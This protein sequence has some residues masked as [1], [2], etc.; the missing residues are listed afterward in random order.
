MPE[1]QRKCGYRKIGGL[2]LVCDGGKDFVCDAL[3]LP[4]ES[5]SCCGYEPQ[6]TRGLQQL[7]AS[8]IRKIGQ[9]QHEHT[10]ALKAKEAA[11]KAGGLDEIFA[12]GPPDICTCPAGQGCPIC[13]TQQDQLYGLMFVGKNNY[14]PEEFIEEALK[15]GVSKRIPEIPRWLQLGKTWILLAHKEVPMIGQKA[16]YQTEGLLTQ[17]PTT[18]KAVFF[19]YRPQR[20]EMPMWKGDISDNDILLLER[21]GIT[22]V[23]IEKNQLNYQKHHKARVDPR[24]LINRL[25][26]DE[27]NAAEKAKKVAISKQPKIPAPAK[28]GSA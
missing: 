1:N 23:L 19:A 4:L 26:L 7:R 3:P 14:T 6:Q 17:E 16:T 10:L 5:C 21:H 20:L 12:K 27:A 15:F 25:K 2:Y 13:N 22:V 28:E 11:Q 9:I 24:D 18:K 8:Y